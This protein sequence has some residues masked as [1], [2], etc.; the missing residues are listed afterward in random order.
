M[1][2]P[3]LRLAFFRIVGVHPAPG[4]VCHGQEPDEVQRQLAEGRCDWGAQGPDRSGLKP[5]NIPFKRFQ[6]QRFK[7]R[8]WHVRTFLNELHLLI[9]VFTYFCECR[10]AFP[11]SQ[12]PWLQEGHCSPCLANR[13]VTLWA[14]PVSW[15]L[16][17]CRW[18]G[19]EIFASVKRGCFFLTSFYSSIAKIGHEIVKD[20]YLKLAMR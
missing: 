19:D 8:N 12:Q 4:E 3:G 11:D 15:R 5:F 1:I 13:P 16:A 9:H 10:E 7:L 2:R 20:N 17:K 14:L 18:F 6:K